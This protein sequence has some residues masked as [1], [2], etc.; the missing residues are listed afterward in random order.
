[1]SQP[2][3]GQPQRNEPVGGDSSRTINGIESTNHGVSAHIEAPHFGIFHDQ[4]QREVQ[5]LQDGLT[6]VGGSIA[7]LTETFSQ[8]GEIVKA[9]GKRWER[10]QVLEEEIHKLRV[11]KAGIWALIEQDREN[12]NSKVSD[13]KKK[14]AKEVSMLQAQADAGE[15]EKA[16][17]EEMERRREDQHNKAKQ[18]MNTQL[19]QKMT[20]IEKENAETIATLG[21]GKT[22]LEN[23]KA[24]LEQ[25][26]KERTKERDQEKETRAIM[27]DKLWKD[28]EELQNTLRDIKAKYQVDTQSLQF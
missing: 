26:L 8:H 17:Y 10:D 16:K 1:M 25:E 13:L 20:Q 24:K 2:A 9:V 21:R 3:A 12:Y 19:Q 28:I 7:E 22:E 11:E 6:T 14:H 18:N 27:Q 4:V 5:R 23:A 15:L